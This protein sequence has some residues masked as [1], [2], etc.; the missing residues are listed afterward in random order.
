MKIIIKND[1][2]DIVKNPN[3]KI[4]ET[5]ES[6]FTNQVVI[7]ENND[8]PIIKYTDTEVMYFIK[9]LDNLYDRKSK[10]EVLLN[11]AT[12]NLEAISSGNSK[13]VDSRP[14]KV[15]TALLSQSGTSAPVATVLENTLGVDVVWIKDDTGYFLTEIPFVNEEN[16][17]VIVGKQFNSGAS[18]GIMSY[19]EVNAGEVSL[20]VVDN[21]DAGTTIDGELNHTSIEIRVY[22]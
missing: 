1:N 14:Y 16:T 9:N 20:I 15:Y 8:V 19:T 3:I 4:I 18:A 6:T 11:I 10:S 2:R 21:F 22:N 17:S 12:D 13:P 5:T 7:L